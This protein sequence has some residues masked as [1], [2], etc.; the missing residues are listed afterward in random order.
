MPDV[1]Q[2]LSEQQRGA[3]A[4]EMGVVVRFALLLRALSCCM[5]CGVGDRGPQEGSELIGQVFG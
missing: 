1:Q 3:A 4:A 2:L 5:P